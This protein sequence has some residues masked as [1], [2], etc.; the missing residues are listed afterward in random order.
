[1]GSEPCRSETLCFLRAKLD[2]LKVRQE[3]EK[4]MPMLSSPSES[5]EARAWAR[6]ERSGEVRKTLRKRL[7]LGDPTSEKFT[8]KTPSQ[9]AEDAVVTLAKAIRRRIKGSSVGSDSGVS[10]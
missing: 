5:R 8:I 2:D 10:G 6:T 4:A 1:M 9:E 7:S 3:G